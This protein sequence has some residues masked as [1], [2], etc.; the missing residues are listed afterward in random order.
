MGGGHIKEWR[1]EGKKHYVFEDN[2]TTQGNYIIEIETSYGF[3]EF[4]LSIVK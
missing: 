4:K 2:I 1:E 3:K